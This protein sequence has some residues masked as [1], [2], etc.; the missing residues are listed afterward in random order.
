MR[1][2]IGGDRPAADRLGTGKADPFELGAECDPGHIVR[3]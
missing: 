3:P 1:L 2:E